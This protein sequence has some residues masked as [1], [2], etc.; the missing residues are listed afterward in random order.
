MMSEK[1]L[2]KNEAAVKLAEVIAADW[3]TVTNVFRTSHGGIY[4]QVFARLAR[5]KSDFDKAE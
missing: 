2:S 4:K 1:R 3:G 5:A